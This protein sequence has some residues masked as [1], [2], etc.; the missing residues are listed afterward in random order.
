MARQSFG[1]SE[2]YKVGFERIAE[3][4]MII[5]AESARRHLLG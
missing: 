1:L 5:V 4:G 3:I 2:N